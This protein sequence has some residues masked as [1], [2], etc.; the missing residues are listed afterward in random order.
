MGSLLYTSKRANIGNSQDKNN[1]IVQNQVTKPDIYNI[2]LDGYTN[3]TALEE[4]FGFDN[5][6]FENELKS[7]GFIVPKNSFSNYDETVSSLSSS[8]NMDWV[9]NLVQGHEI[10]PYRI[11]LVD[12]LVN[13]DVRGILTDQGYK[14]FTFENEFKWSL[15]TNVD[16]YETPRSRKLITSP[17]NSFELMFIKNTIGCLAINYDKLI[18]N[19]FL[20]NIGKANLDKYQEQSYIFNTLGNLPEYVTPKFVFAHITTTHVPYV[21]D[22]NG[23]SMPMEFQGSNDNTDFNDPRIKDGYIISIKYTNR[24]ILEIVSK[25][26][27]DD[28]NAIIIIQGDHGYPG[29][30][31]HNIF[32]AIYDKKSSINQNDCI[33]PIN[34]YRYLFNNWFDSSLPIVDDEIF[35][36]VISEQYQYQL[37]G[38]CSDL[39]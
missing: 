3:S 14:I 1:V 2:V 18:F 13:N 17:L 23:S 22:E 25:I 35:K 20:D 19:R 28:P 37:I 39:P 27:A 21:F 31:R 24:R 9:S 10:D 6:S 12:K 29:E 5:S 26:V 7:L 32:L 4:D 34:L 11:K 8:L 36:T 16:F 30:H 15:W 33:T 38:T